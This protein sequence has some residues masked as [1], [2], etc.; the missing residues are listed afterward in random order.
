MNQHAFLY[1]HVDIPEGLTIRDWRVARTAAAPR[2]RRLRDLF[3]G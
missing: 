3:R 1:E 2:R